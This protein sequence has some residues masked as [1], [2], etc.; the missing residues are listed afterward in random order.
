VPTQSVNAAAA[1]LMT[2]A[3]DAIDLIE[4]SRDD[5]RDQSYAEL[6]AALRDVSPR[7]IAATSC[8]KAELGL[9]WPAQ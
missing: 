3:W 7:L 6:L 4:V 1:V 9:D 2:A 8:L 5:D